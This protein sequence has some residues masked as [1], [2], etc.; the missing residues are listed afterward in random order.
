MKSLQWL[1][2]LRSQQIQHVTDSVRSELLDLTDLVWL[3]VRVDLLNEVEEI[4]WD[5]IND[6]V[7]SMLED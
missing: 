1:A 5:N 3:R 7:P 2:T 4:V 6:L